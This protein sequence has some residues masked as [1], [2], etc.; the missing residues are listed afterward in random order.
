MAEKKNPDFTASAVNLCNPPEIGKKLMELQ[1]AQAKARTLDANLVAM[2]EYQE[3]KAQEKLAA[4]ITAQI[5]GMVEAQGSYQDI[6]NGFY[7]VKQR[8]LTKQYNAELVESLY[9]EY[10]QAIIKKAVDTV[11]LN[12]LVK[13]GLVS[14]EALRRGLALTETE[15]YAF[16]IK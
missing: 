1:D 7:A 16:I 12:G 8:R 14:E 3:L 9:P 4:D 10:A 13:G 5:R 11:K 15:T 2:P 6:D